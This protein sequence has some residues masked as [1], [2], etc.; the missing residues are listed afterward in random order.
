MHAYKMHT[1]EPLELDGRTRRK[2]FA[3][4]M[5]RRIDNDDGFLDN[6]FF[7]D[8]FT[9]HFAGMV[10]RHN[11]RIWSSENSHVPRKYVR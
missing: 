4:A 8:E 10:N 1:V 7:T 6:V 5:L 9:I 3:V 2:E 11:C